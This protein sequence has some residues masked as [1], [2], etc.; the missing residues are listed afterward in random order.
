M[1]N[2]KLRIGVD[3]DGVCAAFI[4]R[5]RVLAFDMFGKPTA[6][7]GPNT[8]WDC[9]NWGLSFSEIESVFKRIKQTKNFW[10]HLGKCKGTE[11]LADAALD[12]SIYFITNRMA[13]LGRSIEEQTC[14]WLKHNYEIKF[15]QVIVTEK[16]GPIAKA[17]ELFAFIDDK[18]ENC[19]E[20]QEAAPSC[21]HSTYIRDASYN[22]KDC[23]CIFIRVPTLDCFLER[24]P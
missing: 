16:K 22:R 9:S 11:N 10:E 18:P 14:E 3:C 15:P 23:G 20:V 12:Y 4:E 13:T 5:F 1:S 7:I 2:N 21:R 17:L 24:L 6:D 8:D 19:K